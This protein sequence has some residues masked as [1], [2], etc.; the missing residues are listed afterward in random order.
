MTI[1]NA[2]PGLDYDRDRKFSK[3]CLFF[4]PIRYTVVIQGASFL[5]VYIYFWFHFV[6]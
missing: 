2:P 4:L 3:V 5:C 1:Q 6:H